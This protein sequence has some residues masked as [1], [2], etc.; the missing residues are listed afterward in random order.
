[1][2]AGGTF[3]VT[4][5]LAGT[6][7]VPG[8]PNADYAI[9]GA[10]VSGAGASITAAFPANGLTTLVTISAM[11]VIAEYP[12]AL[13][14]LQQRV[15]H[16]AGRATLDSNHRF[17]PVQADTPRWSTWAGAMKAGVLHGAVGGNW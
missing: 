5:T 4:L 17:T 6:A 8:Q 16:P 1:M 10:G 13:S 15:P 7:T 9:G 2:R 12:A 14:C 11:P 3:V